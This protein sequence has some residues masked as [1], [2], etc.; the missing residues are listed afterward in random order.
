MK[1]KISSNARKVRAALGSLDEVFNRA[2][3]ESLRQAAQYTKREG[4]RDIVASRFAPK[5]RVSHVWELTRFTVVANQSMN[6]WTQEAEIVFSAS[7]LRAMHFAP[8]DTVH[9]TGRGKRYGVSVLIGGKRIKTGGF[10]LRGSGSSLTRVDG[11]GSTWGKNDWVFKRE[12]EGI[13]PYWFPSVADILRMNDGQY[14]LEIKVEEKFA[15]YF[16]RNFDR[17]ARQLWKTLEK[18]GF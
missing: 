9:S 16:V 17:Q 12:G 15:G 2:C 18:I 4:A 6:W 14:K 13:R 10:H 3:S 5:L 11:T 7:T 8:I 1:I